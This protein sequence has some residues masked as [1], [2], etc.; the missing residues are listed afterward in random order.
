MMEASNG[1]IVASSDEQH[2]LQKMVN[3]Q[4]GCSYQDAMDEEIDNALDAGAKNIKLT[5]IIIFRI[6]FDIYLFITNDLII[7][8]YV[9]FSYFISLIKKI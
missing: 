6:S 9:K 4:N 2:R 5:F 8:F 3:G 7:I 1:E